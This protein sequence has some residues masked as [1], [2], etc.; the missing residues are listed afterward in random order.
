MRKQI[1]WS[2]SPFDDGIK[3]ISYCPLCNRH[4]N[5]LSAK[6]IAQ[7]DEAHLIYLQC[8]NCGAS[9][10]ALIITSSLGISSVGLV[11]DLTSEDIIR[12]KKIEETIQADELINFHR[13]LE[14]NQQYIIRSL[15]K[16]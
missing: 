11:T 8:K 12:F 2:Q 4:Y 7:K 9:I 1:S 16:T 15:L 13:A 5:L 6:I 10:M 14:E 3:I